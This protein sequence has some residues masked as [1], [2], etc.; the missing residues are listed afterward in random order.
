LNILVNDLLTLAKL[1]AG[2]MAMNKEKIE[3]NH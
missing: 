2:T 3:I 1:D